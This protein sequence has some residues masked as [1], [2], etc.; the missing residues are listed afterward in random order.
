MQEVLGVPLVT[1]LRSE[2]NERKK[3]KKRK[4][5]DKEEK[6][7]KV[8]VGCCMVPMVVANVCG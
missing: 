5:E 8:R 4:G 3:N 6:R 2:P 7:P 1:T